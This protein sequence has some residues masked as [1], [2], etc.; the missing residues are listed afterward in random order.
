MTPSAFTLVQNSTYTTKSTI[1]VPTV[2]HS[3]LTVLMI[4]RPD[5]GPPVVSYASYF[6]GVAYCRSTVPE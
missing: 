5:T 4:T 6:T 1:T 3:S 2:T